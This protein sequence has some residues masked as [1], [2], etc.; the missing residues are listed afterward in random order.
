MHE[1]FRRIASEL[2]AGYSEC[3]VGNIDADIAWIFRQFELR[4]IAGT[5]F[6]DGFHCISGD[7]LIQYLGFERSEVTI[8]PS[9]RVS[10]SAIPVFPVS[11]RRIEL[12][13]GL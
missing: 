2:L 10:A 7:E 4:T 9:A 1:P 5:K 13:I 6:D 3:G 11:S 12:R 8:R